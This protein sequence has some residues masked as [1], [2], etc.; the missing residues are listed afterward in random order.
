MQIPKIVNYCS[1]FFKIY[2]VFG[3]SLPRKK[4]TY[5]EKIRNKYVYHFR[6]KERE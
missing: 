1:D 4:L 3:L 5:Y 6:D 2:D